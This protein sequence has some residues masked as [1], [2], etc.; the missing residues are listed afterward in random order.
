[1]NQRR[2]ERVLLVCTALLLFV[3]LV[4][5][6]G[7]AIQVRSIKRSSQNAELAARNIDNGID[8][9]TPAREKEQAQI[10]A[11]ESKVDVLLEV[12]P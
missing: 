5:M 6:T 12:R 9:R 2:W 1:M 4:V 8:K 3:S 7:L 11:I 10:A